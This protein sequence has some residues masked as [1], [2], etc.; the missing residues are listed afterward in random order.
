MIQLATILNVPTTA[1]QA[2]HVHQVL[3]ASKRRYARL[4]CH[5]GQRQGRHRAAR[6]RRAK[7]MTVWCVPRAA[8]A[9]PTGRLIR[10]DTNAAVC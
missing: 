5:Q 4:R 9:A 8:C 2:L 3:G 10:F 7:C 6:S 1:R